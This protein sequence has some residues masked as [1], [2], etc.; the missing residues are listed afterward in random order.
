MK[1]EWLANAATGVLVACALLVTGLVVRRELFARGPERV[2]AAPGAEY[3]QGWRRYAEQ[4]HAMGAAEAPVTIV[5]FSDFQCPACGRFAASLR[6]FR[7]RHPDAVRLVYRHHPLPSHP[8]AVPAARASECAA[9]QGRFEAYHDA[10]FADQAGLGTVPWR[11]FARRAGVPDLDAFDGCAAGAEPLAVLRRDSA[12]AAQLGVSATPTLLVNGRRITGA[13][14]VEMLEA[15]V[16]EERRAVRR[17][18]ER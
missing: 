8:H 4:G 15:L 6:E 7:A 2:A 9:A 3:V 17:G 1:K 5:E 11:E 12:A 10:L 16:R 18:S 13:P 14:P